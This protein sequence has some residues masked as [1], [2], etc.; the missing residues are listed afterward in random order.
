MTFDTIEHLF[1]F[2]CFGLL[3]FSIYIEGYIMRHELYLLYFACFYVVL[4]D[5]LVV[6]L[7]VKWN[8]PTHLHL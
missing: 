5:M 2:V 4:Y 6:F 8:N 3:A 7:V 1:C